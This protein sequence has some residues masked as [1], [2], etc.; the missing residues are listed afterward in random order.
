VKPLAAITALVLTVYGPVSVAA[1]RPIMLT[2]LSEN[3]VTT[4]EYTLPLKRAQTQPRWDPTKGE[5]PLSQGR[6]IQL[7]TEELKRRMPSIERMQLTRINLN[8]VWDGPYSNLWYY[9]V[10]FQSVGGGSAG[11]FGSSIIIVL[12]DG[13]IVTATPTRRRAP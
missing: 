4:T 3:G 1:E 8:R 7:A 6:A 11:P 5:P 12:L 13:S 10:D 2:S 9:S